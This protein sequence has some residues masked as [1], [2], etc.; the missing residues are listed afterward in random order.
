[1]T[2]GATHNRTR[3]SPAA[4]NTTPTAATYLVL[5]TNRVHPNGGGSGRI[6]ELRISTGAAVGGALFGSAAPPVGAARSPG[7]AAGRSPRA[8]APDSARAGSHGTRRPGPEPVCLAGRPVGG[9]D[10]QSDRTR[11]QRPSHHRRPPGGP[12]GPGCGLVFP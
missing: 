11:R 2:H 7:A 3:T 8:S 5:L 9:A 1:T 6:R 12:R 4:E 10:H